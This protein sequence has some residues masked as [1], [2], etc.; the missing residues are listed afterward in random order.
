MYMRNVCLKTLVLA[1]TFVGLAGVALRSDAQTIQ[2]LVQFTNSWQYDQTGRQLPANWMSSAYT[3][4]GQWGAASPG[5]LGFEPDTPAVYTVHAPI[6][7]PLVISGSV[8]TYYFRTTFNYAGSLNNVSLFGTNLVDDGCAIYLNG[9]RVG[10]VRIPAG[11]NALNAAA[12]FTGGT[13]G[14]LETVTFTN[15]SALRVG[16]NLL[17]VEVHQSGNPSSDIMFGM[18][19][20]S[21]APAALQIT[22][23]PQSQT[24]AI[25][26]P[27]NFTV[28]VS[29]GPKFYQWQKGAGS[30][31]TNILNA[32]NAAYAISAAALT[33]AGNYRAIV[34]NILNAVTSSVATLTV[35]ADTEGPELVE[36]IANNVVGGSVRSNTINLFFS[37]NVNTSLATNPASVFNTNN[38]QLVL[39]SNPTNRVPIINVQY[40]GSVAQGALLNVQSTNANW[41]PTNEYFLIVNNITDSR[42]NSIAPN[43]II[44]VSILIT[45]NL[46]QMG[47]TWNFFNLAFAFPEIYSNMNPPYPWYGTNYYLDALGTDPTGIPWGTG[48]GILFADPNPPVTTICAGD[49]TGQSISFQNQPTL[50]RRTFNL[51]LG[52]PGSGTFRFRF[53]RDDGL[54]LFLN[55][56]E[57]K[58]LNM[59]AG[60]LNMNSLAVTN[61]SDFGC[62]TL[63]L[64]VDNLHTAVGNKPGT[65]VLA[66]AVYQSSTPESDTWFG[67]EMD[68]VTKRTPAV[69]P[70]ARLTMSRQACTLRISWPT[71]L[72]GFTLQ[73]K[74]NLNPSTPWVQVPNQSNPYTNLNSCVGTQFFRLFKQ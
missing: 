60:A 35:T 51:P 40:N 26:D 73:S 14:A 12:F 17:A 25:G 24:V 5:L 45:A 44:G 43:S 22:N 48:P 28:G 23:Q 62:E 38:Y 74:A 65:N 69:P 6:Q 29:G 71:N 1:L 16:A 21:I 66:A 59:P 54:V 50:F 30:T 4:D 37:E 32:T 20:I 47:D 8:T 57:I 15:L 42:G 39:A 41:N 63:N 55:G 27:V 49:T 46:T 10:G 31:Y 2:T 19:L 58:R 72:V 7:T 64:D 9:L 33:S 61:V 13:E 53:L 36:A 18:K 67:L 70:P 52:L 56:V 11:Y 68:Y 3:P 34:T